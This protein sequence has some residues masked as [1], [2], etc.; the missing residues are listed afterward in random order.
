[1]RTSLTIIFKT[2][3]PPAVY[4][5]LPYFIFSIALISSDILHIFFCLFLPQEGHHDEG[6]AFSLFCSLTTILL[7]PRT[8]SGI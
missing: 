4:I 3:T 1:M 6:K 2:V 5:P 8:V 7:L